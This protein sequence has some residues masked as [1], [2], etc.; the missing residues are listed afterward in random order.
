M[1]SEP[2]PSVIPT[3]LRHVERS[4]ATHS[5]FAGHA[6]LVT[7]A[8]AASLLLL[9]SLDHHFWTFT[10]YAPQYPRGLTLHISLT[11]LAGDVREVDML[12]HYIGMSSL[13]HAAPLER[14]LAEY[15]I[16]ALVSALLVTALLGGVR[17][18]KWL[19]VMAAL[20]PLGFIADSFY[21]L[22][23]FGHELDPRAPLRIPAFTPQLFGN[24]EIGQFMTFATPQVGF[25]MTVAAVGVLVAGCLLAA[26]PRR[27]S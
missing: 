21:W 24:G 12:N 4:S 11:G 16:C 5:S 25:F 23:R 13:Q 15:G 10:L 14:Q 3:P 7:A 20:L 1:L 6:I 2:A 17:F 9:F 18:R 22:H 26:L 27:S 8:V 19:P